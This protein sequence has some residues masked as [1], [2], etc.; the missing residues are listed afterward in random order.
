MI[1]RLLVF[2]ATLAMIAPHA[3]SA[4]PRRVNVLILAFRDPIMLDTLAVWNDVP[5]SRAE[6]PT[7][8]SWSATSSPRGAMA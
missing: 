3:L 1:R 8:S 5:G 2:A 7:T 6:S 4:Q